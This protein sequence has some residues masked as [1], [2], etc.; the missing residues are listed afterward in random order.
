M[1]LSLLLVLS[2]FVSSLDGQDCDFNFETSTTIYFP[3][4]LNQTSDQKARTIAKVVNLKSCLHSTNDS[5]EQYWLSNSIANN[6]YVYSEIDSVVYY[7][8]L[9]FRLDSTSFC[10]EYIDVYVSSLEED[11]PF[12]PH[13]MDKLESEELSKVRNYCRKHYLEDKLVVIANETKKR[14]R[15]LEN[16]NLNT[17]YMSALHE[18]SVRDQQERQKEEIS[19]SIQEQLDSSNRVKLDELYDMYGFPSKDMV[20]KQGVNNAFM[21]LH[22]STDCLWNEKWTIRFLN[23]YKEN[24]LENLFSFYFYRNFNSK[25]GGCVDNVRFLDKV[26]KLLSSE[27]SSKLLDF[28]KWEKMFDDK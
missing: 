11:F 22:H 5:I 4:A 13:Y 1:R 23:H 12:Q 7:A 17:T 3:K 6:S 19:W 26:K 24:D 20:T 25:D 10:R 18:L 16:P 21:I 28:K 8:L 2:L 9:S 27:A 14:E 15:E